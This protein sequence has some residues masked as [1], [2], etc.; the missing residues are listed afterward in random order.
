MGF[1]KWCENIDPDKFCLCI[2]DDIDSL[3]TVMLLQKIFGL[4]IIYFYDFRNFY[5]IKETNKIPIGCDMDWARGYCWGNHVTKLNK[6]DTYN[7]KCANMNIVQNISRENYTEKYAMS[8][9]LTVWSYYDIPL[10]ASREAQEILLSID[11]AFKGHYSDIFQNTHN[12]YLHILEFDSLMN[13]LNKHNQN[14]FYNIIKKYNLAEKIKI[15]NDGYLGT[16]I[17][18]AELQGFFDFDLQLPNKKFHLYKEYKTK[19]G[20]LKSN[21][22]Y[23]FSNV[24]DKII[25]FALTKKNYFNLTCTV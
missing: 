18:L 23:S 7:K 3:M 25:S 17:N 21:K 24:R 9:I 14:Y 19:R 6:D 10:P 12:K 8:T 5:R 2:G 1:P 22:K 15:N 20:Y 16:N 4:E 13:I 11:T